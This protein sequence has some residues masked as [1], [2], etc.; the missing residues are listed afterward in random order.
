MDD[1]PLPFEFLPYQRE[2]PFGGFLFF[3]SP[4]SECQSGGFAELG[5]FKGGELEESH[6]RHVGVASSV[7]VAGRLPTSG[8]F[9]AG[10]ERKEL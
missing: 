1:F 5:G 3:Q 2:V 4:F 8:G 9:S 6:G 10:G 7:A